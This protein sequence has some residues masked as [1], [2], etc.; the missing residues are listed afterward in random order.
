[1]RVG[2]A[3]R[4]VERR[5]QV[6]VLLPRAVVAQVAARQGLFHRVHRDERR[7]GLRYRAHRGRGQLERVERTAGVSIGAPGDELERAR[8]GFARVLEPALAVPQGA[9]E[10]RHEIGGSQLLQHHDTH[11]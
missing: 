11:P 3:Q 7:P 4:L 5:D 8:T 6:V 2:V 9:F 10:Q 1:M